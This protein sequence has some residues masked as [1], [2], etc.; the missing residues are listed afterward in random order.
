MPTNPFE[1]DDEKKDLSKSDGISLSNTSNKFEGT[2]PYS[3]SDRPPRP[4]PPR[5]HSVV[6]LASTTVSAITTSSH[7][8]RG[9]GRGCGQRKIKIFEDD[10]DDG[11]STRIPKKK[12]PFDSDSEDDDDD[13]D[14]GGGDADDDDSQI[15]VMHG[16]SSGANGSDGST[17]DGKTV[18]HLPGEA[19][20]GNK[21]DCS[22]DDGGYDTDDAAKSSGNGFSGN[23]EDKSSIQDLLAAAEVAYAERSRRRVEDRAEFNRRQG[24]RMA[25]E[26]NLQQLRLDAKSILADVISKNFNCRDNLK[27]RLVDWEKALRVCVYFP[28]VNFTSMDLIERICQG[29]PKGE[30]LS[31][32]LEFAMKACD[33]LVELSAQAVH[34]AT[35]ESI[36]A[37]SAFRFRLEAQAKFATLALHDAERLEAQFHTKGR[38]AV[39]I[40]QQLEQAEAKRRQCENA[41]ILIRRWWMIENLSEQEEQS[42]CRILVDDEISGIIPPSSCLLDPLFTSPGTSLEATRTLRALRGIAKMAKGGADSEHLRFERTSKLIQRLSD[43]LENRLLSSFESTYGNGGQYDFSN[44]FRRPKKLDWMLLREVAEALYYF[45]NGRNL[46][47]QYVQLVVTKQFPDLFQRDVYEKPDLDIEETRDHLS[48]LFTRVYQVC[49]NEFSLIGH[50]FSSKTKRGQIQD[51]PVQVA[52]SLLQRIINDPICGVQSRIDELLES[53]DGKDAFDAG[54]KKLDTFVVIHEKAAGLFQLLREAAEKNLIRRRTSSQQSSSDSRNS[55]SGLIQFL[56]SQ[57]NALTNGHR[58]GYLNLELRHLHHECCCALE[59]SGVKLSYLTDTSKRRGFFAEFVAPVM[60]L[61]TESSSVEGANVY[62]FLLNTLLKPTGWRK[63]LVHATDSLARARLMFG[64]GADAGNDRDSTARAIT[65]IYSQVCIFLG[66]SLLS[67]C[68]DFLQDSLKEYPPDSIPQLPFDQKQLHMSLGVDRQFWSCLERIYSSCKAFDDELW[69]KGRGSSRVLD[70]LEEAGS[71]TSLTVAKERRLRFFRDVEE[72]G[73]ASVLRAL[74]TI[75]SHVRWILVKGGESMFANGDKR[76][77]SAEGPY[78]LPEGSSLS[79]PISP[80]AKSLAD[81]LQFHFN[82]IKNG[83]PNASSLSS[84]WTAL[85]MRIYDILCARLLQHYYVSKIGGVILARD[86]ECVRSACMLAGREHSH[87]DTLMEILT[88]YMT[89]PESIRSI[90]DGGAATAAGTDTSGRAGSGSGSGGLFAR[91]GRD[92]CLV[93]LSRRLDYVS[94]TPAGRERSKWATELLDGLGVKDPTEGGRAVNIAAYSA[95]ERSGI[96]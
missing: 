80:A 79:S 29:C 82:T 15:P 69:G 7:I 51:V 95:A 26:D 90:L 9:G 68:L 13:N 32:I 74:D 73:E 75:S 85:S 45:D 5:T 42:G 81:A 3:A 77:A 64:S 21:Y 48:T 19:P 22:Y 72:R 41:A 2:L 86:V 31:D 54:S 87:W 53:I 20:A 71:A 91:A 94:R 27:N 34:D 6:S 89:G 40:G 55:I 36:D 4:H 46:H 66:K 83:L 65:A 37:E 57:E 67:P 50:V 63:P 16:R 47:K 43:A 39:E 78:A 10:S 44:T 52:R 56:T 59:E 58:R 38:I 24:R 8:P 23:V 30:K 61:D 1:D 17:K 11:G 25:R 70:F 60:N 92:Q 62:D 49:S 88:L 14:N 12:N 35:Q 33:S 84:F 18:D 93:F 28:D 76:P 96:I